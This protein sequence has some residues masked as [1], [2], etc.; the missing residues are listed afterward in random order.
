MNFSFDAN[1][2]LKAGTSTAADGSFRIKGLDAGTFDVRVVDDQGQL[3]WGDSAHRDKPREPIKVELAVAAEKTGLTLTVESRDG[4]I[5]GLVLGPDKKPASDVWISV[6]IEREQKKDGF[7]REAWMARYALGKSRPPTITG[8]DGTFSV[9]RLRHGTYTLVAKSAKGGS[10]IE[11]K[12][13]NTGDTVT[14]TLASL[15]TLKGRVTSGGAPVAKY[16]IECK[17]EHRQSEEDHVSDVNGAYT[18]EHVVPGDYKCVATS[19]LGQ[20]IGNVTVPPGEATLDLVMVPWAS[21]T[22]TI[23]SVLSGEP[24]VGVKILAGGKDSS[25]GRQM[26]DLLGGKGPTSDAAGKFAVPRVAPGKGDLV[27]M[28][29]DAGFEQL[30]KREYEITAGQKLDL[31]TI[32]IVPPRTGDAGTLGMSTD[33]TDGVLTVA[34]VKAG[35]PAERGG[36]VVGDKITTIN[37]IPVATLTPEI[38]KTLMSSGVVAAQQPFQ[39]GLERGGS[40]VAVSVVAEK[41]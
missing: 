9:S 41:W 8:A 17:A 26:M 28:P 23:V 6:E 31:G 30:A 15:G 39:L 19:D 3:A 13:V 38:A 21:L 36:V 10:R 5:K 35:G 32:K 27:V 37:G 34:S 18:L 7:D 16:E 24:V 29:K 2:M 22:G 25:S 12:G 33:V 20:A 14:L 4:V 11:K 1:S 40:P